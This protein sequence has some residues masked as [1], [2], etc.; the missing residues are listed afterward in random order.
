MASDWRSGSSGSTGRR[1]NSTP[2]RCTNSAWSSWLEATRATVAWSSPS[3]T[4][5]EQVGEA[6]AL[7]GDEHGDAGRGTGVVER[8]RHA[9]GGGDRGHGGVD[10]GM[11]GEGG[12][13]PLEEQAVDP[14]GVLVGVD[15]VAAEG[16]DGLADGRDD[17]RLVGT[18]QQQHRAHMASTLRLRRAS[19]E[20][21]HPSAP[22]AAPPMTRQRNVA[23]RTASRRIS[24]CEIRSATRPE[25]CRPATILQ[26]SPKASAWR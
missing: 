8:P 10:V 9:V 7:P 20:C 16:G 6:V 22:T 19:D 4:R 3:S 11:F 15:D 14:V 17:A 26:C 21:G 5:D 2:W 25:K 23:L 24:P 1:W 13:D 12:L 18:T